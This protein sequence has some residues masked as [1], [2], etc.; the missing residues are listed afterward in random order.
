MNLT[1]HL[2]FERYDGGFIAVQTVN[3]LQHFVVHGNNF[4]DVLLGDLSLLGLL[5]HCPLGRDLFSLRGQQGF[6]RP[7]GQAA[8]TFRLLLLILANTNVDPWTKYI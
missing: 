6:N 5:R 7:R 4:L 1:T 3:I 8:G 2:F